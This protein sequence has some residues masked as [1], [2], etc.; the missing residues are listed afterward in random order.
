[1]TE[2]WV[3]GKI[4]KKVEKK[5]PREYNWKVSFATR[6]KKKGRAKDGI[7]TGVRKNIKEETNI[8]VTQNIQERCF[9]TKRNGGYS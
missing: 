5:L 7:I 9:S 2:T 8:K 3:E 6:E 1:M 4:W